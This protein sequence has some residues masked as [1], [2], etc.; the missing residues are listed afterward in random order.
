M[1]NIEFNPCSQST[2]V[3]LL[4]PGGRKASSN[5]IDLYQV[6][7]VTPVEKA[8]FIVKSAKAFVKIPRKARGVFILTPEDQGIVIIKE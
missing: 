5:K 4:P 6:A 8:G 7:S 3:V 2:P 1:D